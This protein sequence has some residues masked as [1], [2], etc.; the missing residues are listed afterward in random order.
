MPTDDPPRPLDAAA[1][2]ELRAAIEAAEPDPKGFVLTA[3]RGLMFGL[4]YRHR[5]ALLAAA[6]I[7]G[8]GTVEG[9]W[10]AHGVRM[11]LIK[12]PHPD[13]ESR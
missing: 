4:F 10:D 11:I 3:A 6:E 8:G 9:R 12:L 7:L 13:A 2:A 5:H 1:I